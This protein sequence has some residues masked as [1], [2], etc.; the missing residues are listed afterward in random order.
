MLM[1]CLLH[2]RGAGLL[3]TGNE[4]HASRGARVPVLAAFCSHVVWTTSKASLARNEKG[5]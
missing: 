5:P 4:D 2:E 1:D 3:A